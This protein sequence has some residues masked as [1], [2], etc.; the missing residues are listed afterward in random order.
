VLEVVGLRVAIF[1]VALFGLRGVLRVLSIRRGLPL[2]LVLLG[3]SSV[4]AFVVTALLLEEPVGSSL[5]EWAVIYGLI[6]AI[7]VAR[8]SAG[9]A[10]PLPPES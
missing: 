1:L 4:I 2:V 10:Q 5:L 3:V 9:P 6:A 7:F 8:R